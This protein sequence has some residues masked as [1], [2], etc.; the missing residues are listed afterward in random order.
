M[1]LQLIYVKEFL[2]L[3]LILNV[4]K[5]LGLCLVGFSKVG[6]VIL[7]QDGHCSIEIL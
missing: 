1:V 5:L 3:L 6:V 4:I 2:A 7:H